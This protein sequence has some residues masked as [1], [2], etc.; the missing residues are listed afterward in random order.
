M[1]NPQSGNEIWTTCTG[2]GEVGKLHAA[3]LSLHSC[4][5]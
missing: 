1:V 3:Y 5:F 2:N 4:N